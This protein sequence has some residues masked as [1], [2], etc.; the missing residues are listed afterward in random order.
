M[1]KDSFCVEQGWPGS[2]W[3]EQKLLEL[4]QVT[5]EVLAGT[6]FLRLLAAVYEEM[7]WLLISFRSLILLFR[8]ILWNAFVEGEHL[9]F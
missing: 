8:Y 9:F 5:A 3:R 1:G 2:E 4:Q 7:P 6:K